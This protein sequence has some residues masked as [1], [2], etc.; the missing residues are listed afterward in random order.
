MQY[1]IHTIFSE[2]A[3][4]RG[5]KL[6]TSA[7]KLPRFE[8]DSDAVVASKEPN[9][10][11]GAEESAIRVS[12]VVDMEVRSGFVRKLT[13]GNVAAVSVRRPVTF[14]RVLKSLDVCL[15][16]TRSIIIVGTIDFVKQK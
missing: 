10:I 1:H 7:L 3:L 14:A 12:V 4:T 8:V 13:V 15:N 11:F 9:V 2:L 6:T 5:S 16:A